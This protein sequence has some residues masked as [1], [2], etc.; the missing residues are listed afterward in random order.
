MDNENR[1]VW[2]SDGGRVHEEKAAEPT[3]IDGKVR[4][5]RESKGRR[6]KTVTIIRGLALDP[7]E[8]AELAG[9]LKKRCGVG[10]SAKDGEITIQGDKQ[11]IVAA[12]LE[13]RG[14]RMR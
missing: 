11:E 6:G 9:E 10:G 7:T 13:K 5:V 2:S 8:L 14:Y 3:L 1:R 12:E 4:I